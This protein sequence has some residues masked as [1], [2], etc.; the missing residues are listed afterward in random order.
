MRQIALYGRSRVWKVRADGVRQR[1]WVSTRFE[2]RGKPLGLYKA[3]KLIMNKKLVPKKR[4]VRIGAARFIR[5][6]RYYSYEDPKY[7]K[8]PEVESPK[9]RGRI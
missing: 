8:R 3:T 7:W 6:W 9:R 4:Y 2:I 1:Y 5:Q